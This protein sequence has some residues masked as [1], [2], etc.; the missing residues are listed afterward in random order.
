MLD[1]E[2]LNFYSTFFFENIKPKEYKWVIRYYTFK[3]RISFF[4][5]NYGMVIHKLQYGHGF[6]Y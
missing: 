1:T 3:T 2:R 6:M 5:T 4:P